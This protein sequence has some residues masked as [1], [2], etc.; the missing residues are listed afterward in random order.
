MCHSC[1]AS[2]KRCFST[3]WCPTGVLFL[4]NK[5]IKECCT[6]YSCGLLFSDFIPDSA[7]SVSNT[8]DLGVMN[9][10]SPLFHFHSWFCLSHSYDKIPI[11]MENCASPL[12]PDFAHVIPVTKFET[13]RIVFAFLISLLTFTLAIHVIG[14]KETWGSCAGHKSRKVLLLNCV[15]YLFPN[16]HFAANHIEVNNEFGLQWTNIKSFVFKPSHWLRAWIQNL[17]NMDSFV[18]KTT[19]SWPKFLY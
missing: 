14:K 6:L 2:M 12:T 16:P 8:Q 5:V 15:H 18:G 17:S 1:R 13:W 19:N 9:C 11:E 3:Q 7:C 4:P 10:V